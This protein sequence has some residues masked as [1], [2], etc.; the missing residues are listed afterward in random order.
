MTVRLTRM[1][2]PDQHAGGNPLHPDGSGQAGDEGQGGAGD[3]GDKGNQDDSQGGTDWRAHAKTWETRANS[4]RAGREQAEQ[5]LG[6]ALAQLEELKRG[7]M[8]DADKAIADAHAKGR[9][10]AL[11]E[12]AALLVESRLEAALAGRGLTD[13]QQKALVD[14]VHHE[15]FVKDGKPDTAAITAWADQV[16]PKGSGRTGGMPDLGQ[17]RRSAP[18]AAGMDDLIRRAW[19][20]RQPG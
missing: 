4:D 17:G 13:Q 19:T 6:Q 20:R 11:A 7:Q 5:Q 3:A 9:Q 2:L 16:A 15:R 18:P 8:S 1:F 10:E 12:T 14:A